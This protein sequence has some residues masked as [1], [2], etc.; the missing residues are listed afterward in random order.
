MQGKTNILN[1]IR[2]LNKNNDL[3]K[4]VALIGGLGVFRGYWGIIGMVFCEML[5]GSENMV[6]PW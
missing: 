2:I 1:L 3:S 5:F 6:S 4:K